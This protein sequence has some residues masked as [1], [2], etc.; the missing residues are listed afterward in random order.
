MSCR[1]RSNTMILGYT[2]RQSLIHICR[3]WW[4]LE[5][6][7]VKKAHILCPI[8]FEPA[9]R[10]CKWNF[11][12]IWQT[13]HSPPKKSKNLHIAEEP[14]V[15]VIREPM[16]LP[17][18]KAALNSADIGLFPYEIIPYRKRTS[19]IFAEAVA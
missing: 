12:C 15:I 11:W 1:F 7:A 14:Q 4:Y 16:S 5:A 8:L 19:G 17:E 9:G 18:Y 13:I 6:H 10:M 3:A 2:A